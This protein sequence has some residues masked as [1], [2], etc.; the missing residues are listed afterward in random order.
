MDDVDSKCYP[1]HLLN[2]K[3]DDGEDLLQRGLSVVWEVWGSMAFLKQA[4]LLN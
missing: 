3:E 1:H 2:L 4:S